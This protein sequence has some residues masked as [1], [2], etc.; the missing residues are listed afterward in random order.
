MGIC[1][2][3]GPTIQAGCDHPMVANRPDACTCL[4]CGVVCH[5]KFGG[6]ATV[7]ARGPQRIHWRRP[8]DT[9]RDAEVTVASAR[10]RVA[11]V[12][13]SAPEVI[14]REQPGLD[15]TAT[16]VRRLVAEVG[17]LRGDI[18]EQRAMVER[19]T[20]SLSSDLRGTIS[21]E[22]ARSDQAELGEAQQQGVLRRQAAM[23]Q[24]AQTMDVEALAERIA[25]E[26]LPAITAQLAR[27]PDTRRAGPD[28]GAPARSEGPPG[29]PSPWQ[30]RTA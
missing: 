15:D 29:G 18:D 10:G 7:W 4:E 1:H 12:P 16:A 14:G 30:D 24:P 23:V 22:L 8:S 9:A 19:L 26:L 21:A 25:A 5:G 28:E 20:E 17:R 11:T 3:F 13:N 27:T 6:C 2:E